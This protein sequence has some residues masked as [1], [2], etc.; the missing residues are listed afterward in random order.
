MNI[1]QIL[2]IRKNKRKNNWAKRFYKRNAFKVNK[3]SYNKRCLK[4]D[5][6]NIR[7]KLEKF[8]IK[9]RKSIDMLTKQ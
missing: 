9:N 5:E 2:R 3:K 1:V 6:E 4:V 7:E 8:K